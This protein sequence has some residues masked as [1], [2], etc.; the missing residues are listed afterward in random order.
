MASKQ[1]RKWMNTALALLLAGYAMGGSAWAETVSLPVGA[2]AVPSNPNNPRFEAEPTMLAVSGTEQT[3]R[4]WIQGTVEGEADDNTVSSAATGQHF[5]AVRGGGGELPYVSS[6][7]S[8][9]SGTGFFGLFGADPPL[10][11][12]KPS[13]AFLR[14]VILPG[15]GQRYGDRNLRGGLFTAVEAGLWTGLFLTYRAWKTGEDDYIAYAHQYGGVV[16]EQNHQF[17]VDIGNYNTRDEY[18]EAKRQQR[19]YAD[20]YYGD[21]TYWEWTSTEHRDVFEET[22]IAADQSKN[23]VY[24]F[25]GGLVL[26]RVLSAIDASRGLARKQKEMRRGRLELGYDPVVNGPSLSLRF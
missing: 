22:R 2:E 23:R 9:A 12:R 25:L 8:Q 19:S 5:G 20:Q 16:G 15:W 14:S 13:E 1:L 7:A 3:L 21:A 24:Y 4:D 11:E 10:M 17:Y 6:S 26:N 18:N